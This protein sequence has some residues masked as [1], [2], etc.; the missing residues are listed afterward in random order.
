MDWQRALK[1]ICS[2][3]KS[4][5]A[6]LTRKSV[7]FLMQMARS[8][9]EGIKLVEAAEQ[10]FNSHPAMAPLWHLAQLTRENAG[11]P[12][13][14]SSALGQFLAD[15]EAHT[16]ASIAHASDWLPEGRILTHSFSS[17]VLQSLV[18]ASK[19]GKKLEVICTAS[20]PGGEGIAL[21]KA[22]SKAN[23]SVTLV[24]DLQ[25]FAWLMQCE[26][27][28]V[29]SDSWCED[30]L[31]HKVGTW[32]LASAANQMG[33]PVWSIGTSE[34][35]LPM[36]WNEKMKGE[37][38]LLVKSFFLQDR[39]LYDLTEWELL[40]GIIDETGVHQLKAR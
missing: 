27:M 14:L 30:G 21:A 26:L 2:D 18:H 40:T 1:R 5:A 19:K 32:C 3:R 9:V 31:V 35:R 33:V 12:K 20:F 10:I 25:A 28:L 22:L 15:M 8:K 6:T 23:V 7:Q 34:K 37:A 4:S 38:P 29:G 39:T 13:S 36:Q 17:L 11:S 16:K 24:S